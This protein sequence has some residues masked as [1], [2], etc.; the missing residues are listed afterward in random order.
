MALSS[1]RAFNW[2]CHGTPSICNTGNCK[3]FLSF[4][5]GAALYLSYGLQMKAVPPAAFVAH[6]KDL[7]QF[8]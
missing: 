2:Y 7:N 5:D 3:F 4:I 6:I 1:D 8:D